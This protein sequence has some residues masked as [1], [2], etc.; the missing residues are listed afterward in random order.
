M[1]KYYFLLAIA[2]AIFSGCSK[3]GYVSLKYPTAPYAA[4][5]ENVHN[6]AIVNRSL[7]KKDN[8]NPIK[9]AILTGEIAGS[10]K[11]ASDECIK[12][13][14]DR[15]NGWRDINILI[16]AHT[17]LY[18]TGT[19]ETPELLGWN[20]V[21]SICD[22]T[23]ADV[24]LVLE[25]FDSN[26]DIL[27]SNVT[28]QINAVINGS[29]TPPP[30][31]QQVRMNVVSF[32]RLY[33]P[34]TQKIID[35]Y[36]TTSYLTFDG[37]PLSIPP[38]DALPKTAYA[39][40][41]EYIQRFLPGYYY[42]KREMYKRGKKSEKQQFKMAFRRSE[43]ANW[44]GASEVWL[45]LTKSKNRK[46]AGRACLNMAVACEVL[47]KTDEALTWAKKAYEDYGNKLGREYANNLKYRANYE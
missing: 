34:F 27:V 33:D 39:A 11:R 36:K 38:P 23:K 22:S 17:R 44:Q 42:V 4:L 26:S 31:V 12:G 5:P 40:G 25:T 46:N 37:G 20:V 15:I 43:V 19:R 30:P 45:E 18:G 3:Y 6:I 35:E 14:F 7:T 16:P 47:G 24:L 29:T 10:D 2:S 8:K 1:K 41:Q 9:E 13:V 32:W 21:K 28:N